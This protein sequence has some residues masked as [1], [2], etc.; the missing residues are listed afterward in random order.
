[1]TPFPEK[2][3]FRLQENVH[4]WCGGMGKEA[5]R[6]PSC[7]GKWDVSTRGKVDKMEKIAVTAEAPG[8]D[9]PMDP[10][11][12]RAAGFMVIDPETMEFEYIDNGPS[13]VMQQGAGIQAAE[14]VARTGAKIVL[15]GFVGPK[16]FQALSAV[17]IKVG[18]DLEN[19]TVRE[20]IEEYKSGKVT[21]AA[22]PNR[23]RGH[24]S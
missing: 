12:G 7:H 5:S 16:A 24:W 11:F 22:A 14:N 9:A 20:A 4:N 13:Q 15:T 3:I 8:L 18:Q 23:M 17:G 19:M 6:P 2:P 21:I 10:R 1:L